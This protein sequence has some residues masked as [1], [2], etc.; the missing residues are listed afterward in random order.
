MKK[1][2]SMSKITATLASRVLVVIFVLASL[3]LKSSEFFF[4][5]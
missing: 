3:I 5:T 4:G 2:S 1:T